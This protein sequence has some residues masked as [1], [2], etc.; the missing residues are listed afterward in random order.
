MYI[1]RCI[2]RY[3]ISFDFTI[4]IHQK[5]AILQIF[6][7]NLTRLAVWEGG[8]LGPKW[9]LGWNELNVSS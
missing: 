7:N 3:H 9:C 8:A 5:M 6:W 4:E 2:K 1:F